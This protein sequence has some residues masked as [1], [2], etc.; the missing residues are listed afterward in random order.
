MQLNLC[1]GGF[2]HGSHGKN[3]STKQ[4]RFPYCSAFLRPTSNKA[5][6]NSKLISSG[7]HLRV[8]DVLAKK[9]TENKLTKDSIKQ[10]SLTQ[11][12]FEELFT[13]GKVGSRWIDIED[14]DNFYKNINLPFHSDTI[15]IHAQ[16]FKE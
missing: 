13:I 2:C 14:L 8:C 3:Y 12:T 11:N 9:Q 6:V 16:Q 10:T 7:Y 1:S 4:F 5:S 15:R